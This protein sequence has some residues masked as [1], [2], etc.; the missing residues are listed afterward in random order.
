MLGLG[1]S[2]KWV[3]GYL[4]RIQ[5]DTID[6]LSLGVTTEESHTIPEDATI[7]IFS[8]TGD[9]FALVD[10]TA[11]IPADVTDGTASELNPSILF[12]SGATSISLIS[13]AACVVTM[14]F[15]SK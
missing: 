10:G 12:I 5:S 9:F 11:A 14:S 13:P 7:V 1:N 3:K 8:S 6:S 2:L 4:A 15:Y